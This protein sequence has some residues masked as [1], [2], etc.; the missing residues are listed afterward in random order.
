[1]PYRVLQVVEPQGMLRRPGTIY[2]V[3]RL[4]VER[5]GWPWRRYTTETWLTL[6]SWADR[7]S[8]ELEYE[9]WLRLEAG[10]VV[11]KESK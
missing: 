9:Q 4:V 3:Q 7:M 1:M 8:A 5:R 6:S 11:V 2:K 10:P